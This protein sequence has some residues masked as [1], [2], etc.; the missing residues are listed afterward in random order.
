MYV[1]EN[2]KRYILIH[3]KILYSVSCLEISWHTI[4]IQSLLVPTKPPNYEGHKLK[5][6]RKLNSVFVYQLLRLRLIS[7]PLLT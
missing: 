4:Q 3:L 2:I 1:Y 7:T 6:R 5:L